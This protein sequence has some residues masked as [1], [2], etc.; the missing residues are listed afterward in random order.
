M[1]IILILYKRD[2]S[3]VRWD[4]TTPIYSRCQDVTIYEIIPDEATK[5][6]V[7]RCLCHAVY[8]RH[9]CWPRFQKRLGLFI[10]LYNDLLRFTGHSQK[11]QE[12]EGNLLLIISGHLLTQWINPSTRLITGSKCLLNEWMNWWTRAASFRLIF[13]ALANILYVY[14]P[15]EVLVLPFNCFWLCL[16][17]NSTTLCR[18][19]Y[20]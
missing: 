15:T 20:V 11:R 9:I 12:Q 6:D 5:D 10:A 3:S 18:V 16:L 4:R 1:R 14:D 17:T 7:I 2:A 8:C 13:E 19:W